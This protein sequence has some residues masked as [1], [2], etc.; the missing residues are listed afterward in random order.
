MKNVIYSAKESF[1]LTDTEFEEAMAFWAEGK[2][3]YCLRIKSLLAPRYWACRNLNLQLKYDIFIE[4]NGSKIH[5]VAR[6]KRTG[7]YYD[8]VEGEDDKEYDVRKIT[9]IINGREVSLKDTTT[10]PE[11]LEFLHALVPIED[12]FDKNGAVESEFLIKLK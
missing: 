8:V 7:V 6:D 9:K 4:V 12:Y 1:M 2:D 3:F 5:D 11:Q 10:E